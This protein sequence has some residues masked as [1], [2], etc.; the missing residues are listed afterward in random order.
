MRNDEVK[1]CQ[2]AH[3]SRVSSFGSIA[4]RHISRC[5]WTNL[6]TDTESWDRR[7]RYSLTEPWERVQ[8]VLRHC[9]SLSSF[10]GQK[11]SLLPYATDR[12]QGVP[13][14]PDKRLEELVLGDPDSM[15]L[16]APPIRSQGLSSSQLISAPAG[17]AVRWFDTELH[18]ARCAAE[19]AGWKS[20]WPKFSPRGNEWGKLKNKQSPTRIS[21]WVFVML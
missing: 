13:G 2:S 12:I 18:I 19:I 3:I 17:H 16:E 5:S 21:C 9:R 14:A 6:S 1:C 15:D 11:S 20:K 8:N 7:D 4:F 10:C